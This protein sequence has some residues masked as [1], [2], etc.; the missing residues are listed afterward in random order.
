MNR[1]VSL[2]LCGVLLASN[3]A[4]AQLALPGAAPAAPPGAAPAA[5]EGARARTP[6]P[7]RA[8]RAASGAGAAAQASKTT[9]SDPATIDGRPLRLNGQSGLLQVSGAGKT[10]RVDKLR[11]AGES[12]SD[13]SQKCIVDIAGEK[14]I[15][16]ASVGRPDGLERFEVDVPACPFA[17]DVLDGAVLVPPQITACVF[18]AADCQTSPGGLWGPDSDSLS[19][20][21]AIAKQRSFAEKRMGKA[22]E[23]LAARAKDNPDAASL[24]RDQNAFAGE[25]DEQCRGYVKESALGYCAASLTE[26]RAALL[27]A[28]LEPLSGA[29]KGDKEQK[30]QK[31]GA[32]KKKRKPK[33]EASTQPAPAPAPAQ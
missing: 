9:G 33:N 3:S 20:A 10:L 17:F 14:P 12:V 6:K 30:A 7:K 18:K 15:E 1:R 22:L 32:E 11:L 4:L 2:L 29:A 23:A 21:A 27:E 19:D 8:A 26:A 13:P 24:V 16:A 25:R 31:T 28:R 5:P